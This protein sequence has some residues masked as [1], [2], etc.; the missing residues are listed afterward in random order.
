MNL[1]GKFYNT[2]KFCLALQLGYMVNESS[3]FS[4]FLGF[5]AS[6]LSDLK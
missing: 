5:W 2:V 6:E 1:E 3:R 4:F